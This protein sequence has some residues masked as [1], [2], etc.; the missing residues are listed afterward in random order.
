MPPANADDMSRSVTEWVAARRGREIVVEAASADEV[1]S[2][3][4]Y[5][6][7]ATSELGV[8]R[9]A[10]PPGAVATAEEIRGHLR[11]VDKGRTASPNLWLQPWVSPGGDSGPTATHEQPIVSQ[12]GARVGV[13]V[14]DSGLL[15]DPAKYPPLD[16]ATTRP[17]DAPVP[18]GGTTTRAARHG[19]FVTSVL[20]GSA[21][22]AAVVVLDVF[23]GR[24][25]VDDWTL[26][27]EIHDYL[28]K[29][30]G[31]RIVNL[32]CGTFAPPEHPPAALRALVERH[33]EVV[34]VAAAGNVDPDS[35]PAQS[36]PAYPAFFPAVI[37]VGALDATGRRTAFT[38]LVSVDVWAPGE[39]TVGI[40]G[41]G[42][43]NG[44]QQQFNGTA[45]W[46][47]TSFAAPVVAGKLTAFVDSVRPTETGSALAARA[48]EWYRAGFPAWIP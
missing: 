20:L 37:G 32:S 19:S 42:R 47:G 7:T 21:P 3:F 45:R 23:K 24:N 44:D 27:T 33:P 40:F 30:A 5:A 28:K 14:A 2:R 36:W 34:W 15:A 48:M 10:P 26:A 4:G 13:L 16:R 43:L 12:D 1:T 11:T 18:D 46:S 8:T 9:M 29:H 25:G 39:H 17:G 41:S 38:D 22:P 6:V 35:L 31:V